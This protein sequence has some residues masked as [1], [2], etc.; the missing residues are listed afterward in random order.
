MIAQPIA[1]EIVARKLATIHGAQRRRSDFLLRHRWK[2]GRRDADDGK[3]VGVAVGR[4]SVKEIAAS[5]W[6]WR[7][8]KSKWEGRQ[9]RRPR[10]HRGSGGSWSRRGKGGSGGNDGI[11]VRVETK[12]EQLAM[13]WESSN[14]EM[15]EWRRRGS[16]KGAAGDDDRQ[17]HRILLGPPPARPN[18]K[19]AR[20]GFEQDAPHRPTSV[21][22]SHSLIDLPSDFASSH[23]SR[24]QSLPLLLPM[25]KPMPR[26]G[27]APF[28]SSVPMCSLRIL[29]P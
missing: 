23:T 8:L 16:G 11:A 28:K 14:E 19:R 25:R 15:M 6:E 3:A 13:P 17:S 9:W 20:H 7:T 22:L 5:R 12:E 29:A 27:S 1:D 18:S 10:R 21:P 24:Q 4:E 26:A 2:R